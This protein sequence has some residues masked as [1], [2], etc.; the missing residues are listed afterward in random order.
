[1]PTLEII[2]DRFARLFRTTLSSAVRK[3][4]DMTTTSVDMVKFGEFMRSLPVPTSLHIFKMDPLRGHAIFVL[5]SKLVF[6]LVET[7]F[8]GAG[9]TDV[10]VEGRDFTAIEQQL[11]GKVVRMALKDMEQAWKPVH[12]V[13]MVYQ[14][15][16]INPQ[17]ASIV[18]PSDVVIVI[19]FE[20]E[21]EHAAGTI[22]VC[23]P[24]STI[25]PIRSKL[26]AGFQSDQLEVDHEWMRRFRE[27]LK[28]AT[29]QMSVE[30]GRTQMDSGQL[31]KLKTGDVIK[32]D[33]DVDD[34][35]VAMVEGVP[36]FKGRPGTYRGA[37]AFKVEG[38]F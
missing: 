15:T 33:K 5:E 11:T 22:T 2:N 7:F 9:T 18:P 8:G 35:L 37:K 3:I 34:L 25:E 38:S 29:V 36:K 30:L 24:Y 20:M 23:V 14:R 21:M 19:K 12:D 16:E 17:F 26:Y 27:Q 6:N 31:L 10:K 28:E 32:L 1:M 4:V 13:T